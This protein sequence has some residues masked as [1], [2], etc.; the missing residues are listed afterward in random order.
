SGLCRDWIVLWGKQRTADERTP[1]RDAECRCR[2]CR[3]RFSHPRG[4]QPRTGVPPAATG[5]ESVGEAMDDWFVTARNLSSLNHALFR[6]ETLCA[7]IDRAYSGEGDQIY[8][9][10]FTFL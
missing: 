3:L 4:G 7:V 2:Q 6:S 8:P 9:Q 5:L 10:P 1:R